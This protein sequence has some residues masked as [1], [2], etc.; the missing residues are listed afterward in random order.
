MES[1]IGA[2]YSSSPR[3]SH[4]KIIFGYLKR[5]ERLELQVSSAA[6]ML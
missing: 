5:R 3:R 2:F 1:E 4:R 6:R